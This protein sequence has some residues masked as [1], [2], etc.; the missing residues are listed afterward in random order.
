[1]QASRPARSSLPAVEHEHR[2]ARG[3]VGARRWQDAGV[4]PRGRSVERAKPA[5]LRAVG[6]EPERRHLVLD[7]ALDGG[8][9]QEVV[10]GVEQHPVPRFGRVGSR[11]RSGEPDNGMCRL[12]PAQRAL[13]LAE[14]AATRSFVPNREAK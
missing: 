14:G 4:D 13:G 12:G 3:K 2:D 8:A 5:C 7:R 1:L 6:A 9:W 11:A 10:E